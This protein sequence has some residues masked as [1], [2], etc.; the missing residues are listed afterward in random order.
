MPQIKGIADKTYP[1]HSPIGQD[2]PVHPCVRP[3]GNQQKSCGYGCQRPPSRKIFRAVQPENGCGRQE[4]SRYRQR[5]PNSVIK[6][7]ARRACRNQA[8]G[9]TPQVLHQLPFSKQLDIGKHGSRPYFPEPCLRQEKASGGIRQIRVE[10]KKAENKDERKDIDS[11]FPHTPDCQRIDQIKLLFDRQGPQVHQRLELCRRIEISRFSPEEK[12]LDKTK[13]RRNM[14]AQLLELI[15]K[16]RKPAKGIRSREHKNQGGQDSLDPVRI[17]QREAEISLL[18]SF[19]NDAGYEEAGNNKKDVHAGE[20]A[21][22]AAGK[23]VK[24]DNR[25]YGNR[26]QP[27]DI[28]PVGRTA[29]CQGFPRQRAERRGCISG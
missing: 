23:G 13:A 24:N 20:P 12:V 16:K 11:R 21:G 3:H 9:P 5:T 22:Q 2:Y 10:R 14:L 6:L 25:K 29:E 4:Q 1:H 8:W 26:A 19:K 15:R 18:H 17:E 7:Q 28:R 27:I